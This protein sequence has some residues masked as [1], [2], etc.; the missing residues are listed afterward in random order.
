MK[1]DV[2][3]FTDGAGAEHTALVFNR[4]E[5]GAD[6]IYIREPRLLS[7]G[8]WQDGLERKL[9]HDEKPAEVPGPAPEVAPVVEPGSFP[10]DSQS[11]VP[12]EVLAGGPGVT[13]TEGAVPTAGAA[14]PKPNGKGKKTP[15]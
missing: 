7:S 4:N 12:T 1:A 10:A 9:N 15:A 3:T 6:I 13:I 14:A 11:V 2:I 5:H 8:N